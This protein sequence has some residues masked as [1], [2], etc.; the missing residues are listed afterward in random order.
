MNYKIQFLQ[1]HDELKVREFINQEWRENHVLAKSKDL[2]DWQY[3][4]K[5]GSYNFIVAKLGNNI[6]GILGFIPTKKYDIVGPI[7]ETG[8]FLAKDRLLS[9]EAGAVLAVTG[10]GAYGFTMSSNYNSRPRASEVMVSGNNHQLI[11]KRETV[12][13]LYADEILWQDK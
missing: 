13:A 8:D 5:D 12:E 3:M 6:I 11:R 1:G 10:A 2:F 9:L 4:N 7:C